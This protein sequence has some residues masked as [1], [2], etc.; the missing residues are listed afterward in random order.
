MRASPAVGRTRPQAIFTNVDLPAPLGP[1][2]PTSSPSRTSRSTPSRAGVPPYSLRS[3]GAARAAVMSAAS[4]DRPMSSPPA[5][6][7]D[8]HRL[9]VLDQT[10]LPHEEVVLELCGAQDT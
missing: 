8:G 2:R 6:H 10:R 9:H 3:P 4:Y 7:W 1:S 5:V